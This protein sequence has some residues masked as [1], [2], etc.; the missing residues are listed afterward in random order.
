MSKSVQLMQLPILI[1]SEAPSQEKGH[2]IPN[3]GVRFFPKH[4]LWIFSHARVRLF[5]VFYINFGECQNY[6]YFQFGRIATNQS[7]LEILKQWYPLF[8]EIYF[9]PHQ[10]QDRA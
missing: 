1:K 3:V 9:L 4:Y 8:F 5:S 7:F 10:S 2:G 6:D